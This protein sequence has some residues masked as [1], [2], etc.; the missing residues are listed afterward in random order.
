M[1][2]MKDGEM[3]GAQAIVEALREADVRHVF[4]IPGGQVL[5]ILDAIYDRSDIGFT[6]TRHELAGAHM[7]DGY[8]RFTGRLGV[9][10]ATT[11]PGITNMV[12]GIAGALRDCSPVLAL[13]VNN[14]GWS[15]DNDDAQEADPV[16]I[17]GSVTKWSKRISDARA[18][19]DA[20]RQAVRVACSGCPGP[21]LLDFTRDAVEQQRTRFLPRPTANRAVGQR[22]RA[23]ADAVEQAAEL[24]ARA[25]RPVLWAGRGTLIAEATEAIQALARRLHMPVITTY[26]GISAVPSSDPLCFGPSSRHG[27]EI[28]RRILR[29]ADL[30][31]TVGNALSASATGRWTVELPATLVQIDVDPGRLGKHVPCEVGLLGDAR[32][33]VEQLLEGLPPGVASGR[34]P[35]PTRARREWVAALSAARSAWHERHLGDALDLDAAPMLPQAAMKV[36]GERL[37]AS[38]VVVADAG[39]VGIWSQL[40]P[41]GRPRHYLKPVGYGNMAF[42]L[43]AAVACK[44]ARPDLRVVAISGDGS[45]GMNMFELETAVRARAPVAVLILDDRSYGNI[46]QEQLF[47]FKA[48]RHIGVDFA[49]VDYAAIARAMGGDG[50]RVDTARQLAAALDRAFAADRPY[51]VDALIDPEVSVWPS[52][53]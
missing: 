1:N 10:L 36:L 8:A 42:A 44:L 26:T 11:G 20:V 33:V 23:P 15:L 4:G 25:E 27:T 37:E 18:I 16:A 28:G 6:A 52:A 13:T 49:D 14:H 5:Y 53:F 41:A 45:L 47:K 19:P 29:E 3:I 31:L 9:C 39:N 50:E 46:K 35:G 38:D 51:V 30:L 48:P 24:L 34:E 12:T 2:A 40:L 43:P 32:A 21:V 7:A 22:T 17:F